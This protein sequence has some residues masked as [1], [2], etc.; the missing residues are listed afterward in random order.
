MTTFWIVS[1]ALVAAGLAVLA[2]PLLRQRPAVDSDR[3]AQNVAIARERLRE[4]EAE[5]ERGELTPAAFDKTK[6]ELEQN[7][8][9]D[10]GGPEAARLAS[11]GKAGL[12]AVAALLVVIPPLTFGLYFHLGA[13]EHVA[14]KG[15]G[16]GQAATAGHG[17]AVDMEAL[18]ARLEQRM[19]QTPDDPQGWA[20]LA[21]SYMAY[22][23]FADAARALERLRGL[24]GDEP[25]VLVSLAD[26]LAMMQDGKLA[27]RPAS[28]VRLAL[29]KE[30]DNPVALWL[31]GNAAAEEGN[32]QEAIDH[33]R[34]VEP[35][36][37]DEPESVQELR[38]R[39]AEAEEKLGRP[40]GA[41]TRAAAAALEAA[42]PATTSTVPA[43]SPPTAA[44]TTPQ[45]PA[46]TASAAPQAQAPAPAA[47]QLV[48]NVSLAPALQGRVAADDTV[49][50]FARATSGPAMPVAAVRLTA[51]QLPASVT[52]DDSHAVMP[53]ARLS[54]FPEV[55]VEARVSKTGNAI[56][57]P[58]DIKGEIAGI[59]VS[60]SQPVSVTID[61][62]IP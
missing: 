53:M 45:A 18:M 15:P 25:A 28:L 62:V 36:V 37:A 6:V 43:A 48:V 12:A 49:F 26:S 8:A 29:Q 50:V 23:R 11:G 14:L 3:N 55:R 9:V 60:G 24:V 1:A 52:L 39:I 33:W 17:E 20:M 47:P 61:T 59:T 32:W 34:K 44:S 2:W 13:P 46:T 57:Q 42:A 56:A 21:R 22:D 31:S 30:P 58:G 4:L 41:P 40:A 38:S 27:G 54:Q 5:R 19:Q 51:A 10:L 35:L 16:A 7:L